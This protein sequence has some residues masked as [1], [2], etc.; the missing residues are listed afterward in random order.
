[1]DWEVWGPPFAVLGVSTIIGAIIAMNMKGDDKVDSAGRIAELQAEKS[2][3]MEAIREL[4]AD[5]SKMDPEAYKEERE[6]LVEAASMILKK[7]EEGEEE[8]ELAEKL[9]G[10]SFGTL[11]SYLGGSM[12]FFFLIGK[13]FYKRQD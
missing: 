12:F 3:I 8:S 10:V 1:M 13:F 2:Q 6:R 4:D 5:Q 7:L 11:A 9:S